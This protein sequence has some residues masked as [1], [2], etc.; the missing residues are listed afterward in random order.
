MNIELFKMGNEKL[1]R[2]GKDRGEQNKKELGYITCMYKCLTLN[3]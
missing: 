3:Y 2:P 1:E